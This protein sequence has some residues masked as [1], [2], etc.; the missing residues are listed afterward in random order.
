MLMICLVAGRLESSADQVTR[1]MSGLWT[2][3]LSG[4]WTRLRSAD[5]WADRSDEL[6]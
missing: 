2:R 1:L 3:L 5:S 4:L 6:A